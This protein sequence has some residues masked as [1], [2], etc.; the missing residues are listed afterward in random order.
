MTDLERF[1]HPR[2]A[3]MYERISAEAERRGTAERRA[4]TSAGLRGR[5]IELG[6]GNGMNFTHHPPTVT[7]VVAVE[8]EGRPRAVA[9]ETAST[10]PVRVLAAH[11]DDLPFADGS[12]DAT[13]ASLMLCSVPDPVGALTELRR[14]LA[15]TGELRFFEHVR[16]THPLPAL[17]QDVVTPRCPAWAGAAISTATSPSSP[18]SPSPDSPSRQSTGSPTP[19]SGSPCPSRTSSGT[20]A[21]PAELVAATPGSPTAGGR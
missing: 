8:P 6:A 14:V 13:V 21:R 1:Q 17:A 10:V 16:S 20:R 2:F 11:A 18:P 15:P 4:R 7:E 12:F 5:V 3:K 19:R 9:E